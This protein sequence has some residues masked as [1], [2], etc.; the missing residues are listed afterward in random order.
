M[1]YVGLAYTMASIGRMSTTNNI[2]QTTTTIV[3][4]IVAGIGNALMALPMVR[5]VKEAWPDCRIVVLAKIPA[6]GEVFA[7]CAA[8]DEVRPLGRGLFGTLAMFRQLRAESFD[9]C[10]IPF[11]SNRWQYNFFAWACGAKTR[12]L[13]DY[14]VGYLRAL[15]F[16]PAMRVPAVRGIHDVAQNLRLLEP[17]GIT[18]G[19]TL[20][21]RFDLTDADRAAA[22]AMLG[23]IGFADGAAPIVVHA[24]SARTILAAAKR[25]P[26]ESYAQLIAAIEAEF[27]P[28]VLLVEGPDE[29][30]VAADILPHV[31]GTPP[32]ILRLTGPLA[33]S[34]AVLERSQLYVG[35]DSGMAHLAAAVGTPAVTLFAPADPDRVCPFGYRDLVV[36][37]PVK[38]REPCSPCL[39]YPWASP[40]PKM[41]CR[42]PYCVRSIGVDAVMAAVRRGVGRTNSTEPNPEVQP[43]DASPLPLSY[44]V[45]EPRRSATVFTAT[46]RWSL[47]LIVLAF[48]GC[49]LANNFRHVHWRSVHYRPAYVLLASA[50]IVANASVQL[51]IFRLLLEAYFGRLPWRAMMA[52]SFIPPLGK[53][54][55]GKVAALGGTMYL[56]RRHG[57]PAA[58]AFSV[59]M[60]QDGM[61]VITGLMVAAPLLWWAPVRDRVPGARVW[62][63]M[64][65]MLGIVFLHPRVFTTIAN[66]GLRLLK[67]EPLRTSI[68]LRDY[69]APLMVTF[70]QWVFLGLALWCMT[71]SVAGHALPFRLAPFF[72]AVT[73]LGMTI[74]YLAL[75]APGGIG[76]REGIFLA[77]LLPIVGPPVAVIIVAMRVMQTM[78]EI[79]LAWVGLVALRSSRK[80]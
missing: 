33:T 17:L 60:I 39:E 73:A 66:F 3:I 14:P 9:L 27:G 28:R 43:I 68:T 1:L 25:W 56:L 48:V 63:T 12:L 29:A 49:A 26:P 35:T 53:Y 4:P 38:Q 5:R 74:G 67:R 24:G 40:Y 55:P 31:R 52:V 11:P 34:A 22:S 46:L 77:A 58:V 36:Q 6:M 10:L 76:V 2:Q 30:G 42:E 37:P 7:R 16:V 61:A 70:G 54:L 78:V 47:C 20:P 45:P 72:M 50:C 44:A 23:E 69:A 79:L 21:P 19:P 18:P 62:C 64:V 13:H 80:R 75:I 8:V 71:R 51:V 41:H 32:R 59:A 57:V 65:L 15:G